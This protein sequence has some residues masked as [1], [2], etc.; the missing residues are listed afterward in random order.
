MIVIVDGDGDGDVAVDDCSACQMQQMPDVSTPS[1]AG[2][3]WSASAHG[4]VAVAVAVHAHDHVDV[5]ADLFVS[6]R[7]TEQYW[8]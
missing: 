4:H 1:L 7:L 5:D 3:R 2:L 6:V 8:D